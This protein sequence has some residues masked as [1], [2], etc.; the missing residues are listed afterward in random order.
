[1][2]P[3][4]SYGAYPS[5]ERYHSHSSPLHDSCS[6]NS[7]AANASSG[8]SRH[9]SSSTRT[10][11]SG[12][13]VGVGLSLVAIGT[14]MF[15]TGRRLKAQSARNASRGCCAPSNANNSTCPHQSSCKCTSCPQNA[16]SAPTT[17][18]PPLIASYSL[19]IVTTTKPPIAST[20]PAADKMAEPVT[21]TESKDAEPATTT[22]ATPVV[23]TSAV[24]PYYFD[25]EC[26]KSGDQVWDVS[27]YYRCCKHSGRAKICE[28]R[29]WSIGSRTSIGSN[30]CE[31][32]NR[33]KW[34]NRR[35]ILWWTLMKNSFTLV[36]V[37]KW[38]LYL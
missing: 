6:A 9:I 20:A 14:A 24:P 34:I 2:P 15:V 8:K 17:A 16:A 35:S 18:R 26:A 21:A 3:K 19:L 32:S 29:I 13:G 28:L 4:S 31:K 12:L 22:S 30:V 36:F 33:S 23:S 1:M 5:T 25:V 10:F 27:V 38:L 7:I 11:V 37:N